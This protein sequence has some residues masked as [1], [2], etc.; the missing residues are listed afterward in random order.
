[1][2]SAP[3]LTRSLTPSVE[4]TLPATSGTRRPW[5]SASRSRTF[6]VDGYCERGTDLSRGRARVLQEMINGELIHGWKSPAVHQ[7]LDLCLSCKGCA[8]DLPDEVR[9]AALREV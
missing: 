8:R 7:A 2:T 3:A 9:K 5:V 4:T 6:A 1:M